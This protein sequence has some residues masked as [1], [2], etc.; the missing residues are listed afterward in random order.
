MISTFV[1]LAEPAAA[2]R[3]TSSA[4]LS[5]GRGICAVINKVSLNI[6]PYTCDRAV[7]ARRRTAHA[8]DVRLRFRDPA[9]GER[10][11]AIVRV[12][13]RGARTYS[14]RI[15]IVRHDCQANPFRTRAPPTTNPTNPSPSQP[16]Y[17]LSEAD[18]YEYVRQWGEYMR[19]N[20]P[21]VYS[22]DVGP[23]ARQR[24]DVVACRLTTWNRSDTYDGYVFPC[25]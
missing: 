3:L 25:W 5:S 9:N 11:T 4:A 12:A 15:T 18:A 16:Q 24:T 6:N 17:E 2:H 22:Y 1:G 7:V 19:Q 10:C 13:F 20:Y 23:C 14:R 21:A 8:I